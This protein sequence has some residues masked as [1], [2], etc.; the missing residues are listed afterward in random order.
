VLVGADEDG[1]DCDGLMAV[2]RWGAE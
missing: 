2:Q 1:G